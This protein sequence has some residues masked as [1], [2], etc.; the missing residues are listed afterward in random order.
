M[1]ID[2]MAY[3]LFNMGYQNNKIG[4]AFGGNYIK[5]SNALATWVGRLRKKHEKLVNLT[6]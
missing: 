3:N 4:V 1:P 2:E 6:P 5:V